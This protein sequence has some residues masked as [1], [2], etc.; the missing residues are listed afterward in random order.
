MM[1]IDVLSIFP[2]MFHGPFSYSMI[3]RAQDKGLVKIRCLDIRE[4]AQ[5]KHRMVDDQPYGG[6]PGMIMKIEPVWR[7]VEDIKGNSPER[8]KVLYVTPQGEPYNQGIA[9]ELAKE[10]HLIILC[11]R[12]KDVDYRIRTHLI[13]REISL[14]DYILTGGELAAM[15][16]VDSIVRLIPDVLGDDDSATGDSFMQGMLDHPHYTRPADFQGLRVPDVLL[17]GDHARIQRWRFK[18]RIRQ[19]LLLRPDLLKDREMQGREEQTILKEVMEE[20]GIQQFCGERRIY[21]EQN[22]PEPGKQTEED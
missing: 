15:V 1:N 21:C 4:Y 5:D 8:P 3:Q 13:H 12:Y 20:E 9:Q 22:N 10:D 2:E 11:G 14:G 17:S 19:T 6:G 18:E 16:L 7:A